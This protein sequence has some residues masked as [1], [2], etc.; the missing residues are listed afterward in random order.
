MHQ[1]TTRPALQDIVS[2]PSGPCES[3]S[4]LLGWPIL[5]LS[6]GLG[7]SLGLSMVASSALHT[8]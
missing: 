7:E 3:D 5:V 6:L 1:K 4:L 2:S 8:K